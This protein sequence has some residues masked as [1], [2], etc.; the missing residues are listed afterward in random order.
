MLAGCFVF[1]V[2]AGCGYDFWRGVRYVYGTRGPGNGF[3]PHGE[4]FLVRFFSLRGALF[5]RRFIL[6]YCY[7]RGYCRLFI[8]ASI[9]TYLP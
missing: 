4:A 3:V 7:Y 8:I 9:L 2:V 1:V 5:W 6:F